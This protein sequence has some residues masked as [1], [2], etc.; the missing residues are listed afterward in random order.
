MK[1]LFLST[2]LFTA[3]SPLF[4][5]TQVQKPQTQQL[6]LELYKAKDF[7]QLLGMPGFSDKMLNQHFTLYQGY[8]KNTNLLLGILQQYASEGADRTPQYGELKRRLGWEFDGMRLHEY[9]FGNLGG[10]GSQLDSKTSLSKQIV[11]D[12]GSFDAWKKDFI[13]SGMIR[14]I[15]WVILYYDPFSNRLINTWIGEHDI[16]HLASSAPI[17]IMDVWEHAYMPDYG[18]NREDYIK[19]FFENID[20]KVVE[21]RYTPK[22]S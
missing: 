10:K 22:N 15:G 19:A 3:A 9:Y 11:K 21:S 6:S 17:L 7:S 14:G 20:W 16:G 4:A 5:E 12:F 2:L 18:I 8:V 1:K 13:A